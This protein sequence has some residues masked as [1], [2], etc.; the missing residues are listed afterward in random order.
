MKIG[1]CPS[2]CPGLASLPLD[3]KKRGKVFWIGTVRYNW[4]VKTLRTQN[5]SDSRHFGTIRLVPKCPDSTAPVPKCLADTSALVPNCLDF[6]QTFFCYS[7]HTEERFTLILV[8]III[9]EDHWFY[10]YTQ[11]Y[12]A[13]DYPL[14]SR[15]V[16]DFLNYKSEKRNQFSLNVDYLVKLIC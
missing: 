6:Q 3:G 15:T 16:N 5:T 13:D 7:S 2:T 11:E 14:F 8:V 4:G 10:S 1:N 9:K 12:T